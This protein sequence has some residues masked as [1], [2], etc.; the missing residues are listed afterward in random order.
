[1]SIE[2][3]TQTAESTDFDS[4]LESELDT[5]EGREETPEDSS[6]SKETQ[7]TETKETEGAGD[8]QQKTSKPEE[9]KEEASK[10]EKADPKDLMFRK[11]YNEA[12]AKFDKELEGIKSQLLPKEEVETFRSITSSPAYIRESMRS[13]GYKDEVIDGKLKELGHNVPTREVDDVALV[14]R[15]LGYDPQNLTNEQRQDI[16]YVSKVARV[17]VKHMMGQ[18]LPG[19]LKPFKEGMEEIQRERGSSQVSSMIQKTIK[20]EGILDYE[21][22]IAPEMNRWLDE[23]EGKKGITQEDFLNHF[24][25]VNHRLSIERLRTGKRREDRGKAKDNQ[26]PNKDTLRITPGKMPALTGDNDKD[27]DNALDALGIVT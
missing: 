17:M 9:T 6:S 18:E 24:H 19:Q 11:A 22:D 7:D 10:E 26:R 21:K 14:T 15:E 20:D 8:D 3:N 23:N 16:N 5:L 1:M 25:K 13:Q 12:K 2:P 4:K 27:M